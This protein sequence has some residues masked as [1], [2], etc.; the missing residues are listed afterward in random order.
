MGP[1]ILVRTLVLEHRRILMKLLVYIGL[2]LVSGG[3][4]GC[5]PSVLAYVSIIR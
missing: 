3:C 5:A 4:F 2:F 1:G